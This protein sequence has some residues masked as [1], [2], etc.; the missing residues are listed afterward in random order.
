MP[1]LLNNE[2]RDITEIT[3]QPPG[4]WENVNIPCKKLLNWHHGIEWQYTPAWGIR[5]INTGDIILP[6]F[7]MAYEVEYYYRGAD[8]IC[9]TSGSPNSVV[10]FT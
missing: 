2:T 5:N 8:E 6:W 1:F 3:K 4:V 7:D 10:Q 9:C